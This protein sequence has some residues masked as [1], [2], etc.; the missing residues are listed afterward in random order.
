MSLGE[1][2]ALH[3]WHIDVR[4]GMCARQDGTTHVRRVGS[5]RS[6]VGR[7]DRA[8]AAS[9]VWEAAPLSCRSSRLLLR[10]VSQRCFVGDGLNRVDIM[11]VRR[12]CNLY[13]LSLK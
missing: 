6:A 12:I 3:R 4:G 1:I 11:Q 8:I 5:P 10:N 7:E 13:F 2:G 9:P